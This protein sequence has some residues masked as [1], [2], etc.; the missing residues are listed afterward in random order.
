MFVAGV[1]IRNSAGGSKCWLQDWLITLEGRKE[2]NR[3]FTALIPLYSS[4]TPND[5]PV[6]VV[7]A[8]DALFFLFMKP[9]IPHRCVFGEPCLCGLIGLIY[10]FSAGV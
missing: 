2:L 9:K 8:V 10:H 4:G 1:D 6:F 5:R 3:L 7:P